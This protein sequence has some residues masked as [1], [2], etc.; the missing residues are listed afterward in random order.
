MTSIGV[1]I[2]PQD[3]DEAIVSDGIGDEGE[4]VGIGGGE[5]KVE[6]WDRTGDGGEADGIGTGVGAGLSNKYD[7]PLEPKKILWFRM[8][9]KTI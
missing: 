2:G 4:A 5:Y 3:E 8:T 9:N 7:V 1:I 6:P